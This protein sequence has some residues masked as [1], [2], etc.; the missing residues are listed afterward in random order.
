MKPYFLKANLKY[1]IDLILDK[2]VSKQMWRTFYNGD[3]KVKTCLS[4]LSM[5]RN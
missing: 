4:E 5:G 2:Q 1:S 3:S